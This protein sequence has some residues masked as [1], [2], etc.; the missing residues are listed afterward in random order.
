MSSLLSAVLIILALRTSCA[1]M[2]ADI[3]AELA[4]RV[5][6]A[7]NG[8]R[9]DDVSV[10][11]GDASGEMLSYRKGGGAPEWEGVM[12][13]ASASKWVSGKFP[14]HGSV[15]ITEAR[16]PRRIC[17]TDL[18]SPLPTHRVPIRNAFTCRGELGQTGDAKG[19][20]AVG[21]R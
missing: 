12:P 4:K 3:E 6:A 21:P 15:T 8:S 2:S 1:A 19:S 14:Q 11:L 20:A 13:V 16:G 5:S 17:L 9:F 7:V 10:F 18:R